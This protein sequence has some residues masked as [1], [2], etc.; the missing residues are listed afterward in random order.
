MINIYHPHFFTSSTSFSSP[1]KIVPP[2]WGSKWAKNS[3]IW[4]S[5]HS[6]LDWGQTIKINRKQDGKTVTTWMTLQVSLQDNHKGI[7]AVY[8]SCVFQVKCNSKVY[9]C[10]FIWTF[11]PVID[12]CWQLCGWTMQCSTLKHSRY[13]VW[14]KIGCKLIYKSVLFLTMP[15]LTLH[16]DF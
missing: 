3:V 10:Q 1:P 5:T 9:C 8:N 16:T 2:N 6:F 4:W 15:S 13:R 11:S 12:I 14:L 7:K